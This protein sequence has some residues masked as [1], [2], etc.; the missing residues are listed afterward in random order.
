MFSTLPTLFAKIPG[1]FYTAIAFFTLVAFAAVSS[2]ISMLEVV[3]SYFVKSKNMPRVPVTIFA[4]FLAFLLGILSVFSFN[5]WSDVKIFGFGFFDFF[6]KLTGNIM[7]PLGGLL[8][9]TFYGW[10]LADKGIN[11]CTDNILIRN[12]LK[13]TCRFVAPIL[14]ILVLMLKVGIISFAK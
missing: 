3:V 12:Y 7:L 13:I 9:A 11:E 4:G 14:V 8:I 10:V 1:G 6:D 2:S 5:I